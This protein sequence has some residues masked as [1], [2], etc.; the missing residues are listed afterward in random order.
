MNII[1]ADEKSFN[2]NKAHR[3]LWCPLIFPQSKFLLKLI[4]I[5]PNKRGS[6]PKTTV[7]Y[8]IV[9]KPALVIAS[10]RNSSGMVILVFHN[11]IAANIY[12]NVDTNQVKITLKMTLQFWNQYLG[13]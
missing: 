3:I 9:S 8:K 5:L 2:F 13:Q 6:F 7:F 12:T 4:G 11:S 10:S 1:V